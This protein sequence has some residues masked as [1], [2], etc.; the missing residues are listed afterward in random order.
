MVYMYQ[1]SYV[2]VKVNKSQDE[3]IA[4]SRRP[5]GWSE[6]TV[7]ADTYRYVEAVN[8]TALKDFT[9][10]EEHLK[11]LRHVHL[12]WDYGEGYGAPAINPKRPYGDSYVERSIAEI[13]DAP[14]SDWEA[15]EDDDYLDLT[16]EAQERFTRLHVE[17]MIVL[18]IT[19][20]AGE[21]RPGRYIRDDIIGW[22]RLD[23][24]VAEPGRGQGPFPSG[25]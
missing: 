19:L 13:L 16:P 22:V 15:A 10:T 1:V 7:M 20:A 5:V 21:L 9:V 8:W 25:S 12:Y 11:L 2:P 18:H 14:D 6:E 17:T 3:T 24:E 4:T 23:E